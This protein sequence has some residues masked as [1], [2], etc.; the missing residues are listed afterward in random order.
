MGVMVLCQKDPT[1]SASAHHARLER[2][3]HVAAEMQRDDYPGQEDPAAHR[4]R[5]TTS[6]VHTA[7]D[8]PHRY[9]GPVV[10]RADASPGGVCSDLLSG[11]TGGEITADPE[12]DSRT[13]ASNTRTRRNHAARHAG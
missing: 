8:A 3:A 7:E 13:R 9:E 12:A 11:R 2:D 5:A 6:R 10:S 4:R 1:S